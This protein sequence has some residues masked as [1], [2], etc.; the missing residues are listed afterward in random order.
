MPTAKSWAS[1][2]QTTYLKLQA[3]FFTTVFLDF[4]VNVLH[5]SITFHKHVSKSWTCEDAHNFR[6]NWWQIRQGTSKY[7]VDCFLVHDYFLCTFASI[8]KLKS[9]PHTPLESLSLTDEEED[10][11]GLCSPSRRS[12]TILWSVLIVLA[13]VAVVGIIIGIVYGVQSTSGRENGKNR[14][15]KN[16]IANSQYSSK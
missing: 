9:D 13:L 4:G 10:D 8:N 14:S 15:N 2:T 1:V 5:Q 12:S 6:A 3:V 11:K 7:W 16:S